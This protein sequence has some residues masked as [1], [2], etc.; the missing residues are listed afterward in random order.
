M[1]ATAT[2]M[3]NDDDFIQ[4]ASI[5]A[6]MRAVLNSKE[7]EL[8]NPDY[9]AKFF[10]HESWQSFLDDP[11]TSIDVLEKRIPGGVYYIFIRTK[12]FDESLSKWLTKHPVSQIVLLGSGFDSR[13]LRFGKQTKNTD[14]YEVDLRS[15]LDY[16]RGIIES[17]SLN[18]NN[19]NN[20][21]YV[22]TNFQKDDLFTNLF[23]QGFDKQK[24]TYFL[25]EGVSFF[26]SKSIIE[27]LF[28]D[29]SANTNASTQVVLDYA[30]QDYIEGDLS[31]YGAK[32]THQELEALNEPHVFGINYKNIEK[33][34]ESMRF[35]TRNNFTSSMLNAHYL[36]NKQGDTLA[37]STSFFGLTEVKVR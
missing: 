2:P 6:M 12:Y 14:F 15:M 3:R 11:D 13:A 18:I 5:T 7:K 34:F 16:K 19:E 1:Y 31:Y 30:F 25:C 22:P 20:I 33:F 36:G 24:P 29:I 17:N 28:S 8:K 37:K 21:S 26:L 32:E 35:E 10:V 23:E 4:S 9:L 27:K